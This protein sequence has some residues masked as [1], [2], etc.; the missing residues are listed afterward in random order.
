MQVDK[1]SLYVTDTLEGAVNTAELLIGLCELAVDAF[2]LVF[3][4]LEQSLND[5]LPSTM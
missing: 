5:N 2:E 4:R 1:S 3:S